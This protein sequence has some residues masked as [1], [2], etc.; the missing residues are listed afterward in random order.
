[1]LFKILI[2]PSLQVE[3]LQ[4][5]EKCGMNLLILYV[6]Q[7]WFARTYTWDAAKNAV[8]YLSPLHCYSPSQDLTILSS[9]A[10]IDKRKIFQLDTFQLNQ[11]VESQ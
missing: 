7:N 8:L 11:L 4:W 9:P 1:M 10:L 3:Q 2:Y 5:S 6:L